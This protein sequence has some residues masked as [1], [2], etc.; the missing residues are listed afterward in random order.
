ML[1]FMSAWRVVAAIDLLRVTTHKCITLDAH[2]AFNS[3][4]NG[5]AVAVTGSVTPDGI[6]LTVYTT[7]ALVAAVYVPDTMTFW[8]SG[9]MAIERHDTVDPAEPIRTAHAYA[10]VL[11]NLMMKPSCVP[12][13]VKDTPV[14][15]N[16]HEAH[17]YWP[18]VYTLFAASVMQPAATAVPADPPNVVVQFG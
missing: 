10:V 7:T 6:P 13:R 12:I 11:K 4:V 3:I 16:V 8:V 2:D 18:H 15:P 1:I 9:S 14:F 17:V 5:R